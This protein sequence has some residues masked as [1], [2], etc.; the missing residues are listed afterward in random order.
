[1]MTLPSKVEVWMVDLRGGRGHEQQNERPAIVWR[2]QDHVEMAIIIP[3]TKT[4]ERENLP[5]THHIVPNSKNGLSEESI[6][7]VFQ[8]RSISKERLVKKLGELGDMDIKIIA[9]LLK[10]LLKLD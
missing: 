1:M 5:Y 9:G 4:A 2:R 6:A 10:D 7:L 8:V 3:I